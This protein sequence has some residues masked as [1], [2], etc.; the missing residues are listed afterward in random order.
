MKIRVKF[1]L[2]QLLI[3]AGFLGSM[4]FIFIQFSHVYHLK[5]LEV[6][7]IQ[8]NT[9]LETL[10]QNTGLFTSRHM[11]II[12]LWENWDSSYRTF[13]SLFT[14]MED[15]PYHQLL[16]KTALSGRDKM[17]EDWLS[18][19]NEQIRQLTDDM[20]E[21]FKGDLPYLV[22]VKGIKIS[23]R[24]FE[25]EN[26]ISTDLIQNLTS[27]EA[28]FNNLNEKLKS[29]ISYPM[30]QFIYDLGIEIEQFSVR[31][32]RIT[33]A[34]AILIQAGGVLL[35]LFFT[36]SF[37]RN[38]M[39]LERTM[40]EVASG[41]FNINLNIR[42]GDEFEDISRHFN[43]LTQDLWNRIE[44]MKDMMRDIGSVSGEEADI[45]ELEDYILELAIDN[46]GADAGLFM[47]VED[48]MLV[49]RKIQGFFPPPMPLPQSAS[50]DWFQNHRISSGEGILGQI[51]ANGEPRFVRNNFEGELPDN[52]DPGSDIYI[53]SAIFIPLSVSGT[54]LGI[55]ALAL[56]RRKSVF[57]D[58][59]Y[60]YMRSYGEFIAL[61][62]DNMQK[63]H[64]LLRSHQ[65]NR[66]IE[67]AADIQKTLLPERLPNLNNAE[68]AAFSDAAK[69]VSGDYYDVFDLGGGKTA[70]II[71]DVSGKGVPASLLMIMIRTIIRSISSPEKRSNQIMAELN[72]AVTGRMG[73]DRFATISIIILDAEKGV[74]S[75]SNGAHH[76]LYILRGETGKYRMFDTDGLPLGID[77]NASF[78]H[79]KIRVRKNDYLVLFTDGLPEARNADGEELGTDRLL[80]FIA[81]HAGQN[82]VELT[83]RVRDYIEDFTSGAK[84]DDQTFVSLKVG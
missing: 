80:R 54:I 53:N 39:E 82:P 14:E 70:V 40:A 32:Y 19:K 33:L 17:A 30:V 18:I 76:P 3:V 59:D 83:R 48:G 15:N 50:I 13:E 5:Q 36:R 11:D 57:T 24:V 66:E 51:L 78:G 58:M 46:A 56:T 84:H 25:H 81:R 41:N 20:R 71:C 49:M 63:Y 60:A 35:V 42:S 44:S 23:K 26:N 67:V 8:T 43:T 10:I 27:I 69:G 73:S 12:S 16:G 52:S 74:V 77:I 22:G 61:T 68:V 9:A 4:A 31:L 38:T 64:E 37:S 1:S 29:S 47:R 21:T 65:V 6:Q 79:K 45:N 55:L 34:I 7:S 62:L 28:D 72:R 2:F 75:Y